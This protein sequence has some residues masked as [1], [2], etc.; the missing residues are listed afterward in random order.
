MPVPVA[1]AVI[2]ATMGVV[3][4]RLVKKQLDTHNKLKKLNNNDS[5]T[6]GGVTPTTKTVNKVYRPSK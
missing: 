4:G 3:G 5:R 2:G 6:T 1:A